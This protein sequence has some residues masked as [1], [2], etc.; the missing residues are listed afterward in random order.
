MI[1]SEYNKKIYKKNEAKWIAQ[2][3]IVMYLFRKYGYELYNG[4]DSGR[5]NTGNRD[6]LIKNE[7]LFRKYADFFSA[8]PDLFLDLIIAEDDNFSLFFY[9]RI[10]LRAMMRFKDVYITAGRA[11]S[12]SFL[13]IVALF[14]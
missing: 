6:F 10:F 13:S 7:K 1:N 2:E 8:Y 14:L 12:K 11:T 5:D 9:Q 4:N 3:T